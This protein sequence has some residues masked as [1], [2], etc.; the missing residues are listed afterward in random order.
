[1]SNYL[2]SIFWK[3]RYVLKTVIVFMILLLPVGSVFA[4]GKIFGAGNVAC[5]SF[6]TAFE[7]KEPG[8]TVFIG[9]LSWSTGYLTAY[10]AFTK[11]DL[12]RPE[13]ASIAIWLKNY[14]SDH[15]SDN[16]FNA[17]EALIEAVI[18]KREK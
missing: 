17:T 16:M 7:K 11:D 10:S 4:E 15:A 2:L 9:V 6:V 5:E 1:M 12:G 8:D 14:C 13:D 3:R 18:K